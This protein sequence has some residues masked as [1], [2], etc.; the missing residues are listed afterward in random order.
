MWTEQQIIE[1]RAALL[2]WYDR[3]GRTLPWRVRPE[4]RANG[5][6]AD[7]YAV[8]LS[9]IMLQQTTIPHGTPY[10]YK[11][12]DLYPSVEALAAAPLDDVLTHWAGLGYYARARNLHKCAITVATERGG[13]FPR[14]KTELLTLPGIGDYTASTIAAICFDQPTN[15]VDGNVERVISRMHRVEEPLPK[16]KAF[17]KSLA[18][19]IA[20]SDRPG[21]YGQAVMDLGATVCTPR[22]PLCD[23]CPWSD[24]CEALEAGDQTAYPKKAP[25]KKQPIR[26][27]GAYVMMRDGAV[28][29]RRRPS[30]GLLGGM[31]EVPT[32]EWADV[33]PSV[34]PPVE[35]DWS[36]SPAP[37]KHVFTHFELRLDVYRTEIDGD[38]DGEG[39]W[40][41]CEALST[42][43]LPS[44]FKK[45]LRAV[46]I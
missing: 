36:R 6:I 32:S 31:M 29:L 26:F 39:R 9:E 21:D 14:T 46:G 17:I 40:V 42:V 8:W 22:S 16:A 34:V 35:A 12:L 33:M 11:F 1:I 25:K 24:W 28:W 43:A 13:E 30:E 15:I 2:R 44:L 20:D 18:A 38:P 4:D 27:G 37:V 10:W 19:V 41:A 23:S 5:V 7:P 45:V 3:Q